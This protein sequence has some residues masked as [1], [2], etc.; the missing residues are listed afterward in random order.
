MSNPSI[1]NSFGT[2]SEMAVG[3]QRVSYFRLPTITDQGLADVSR[4]PRTIKVLLEAVLRNE[5]GVE[6]TREDVEKLIH[7]NPKAPA[8]VE[9]PFKPARV[10]MQD[11]TGVPAIVDLA[12]LRSAMI[13]LGKDPQRINPELPVDLVIDHSVQVDRYGTAEALAANAQLEFSRNRERY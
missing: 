6:V 9:I 4:L 8:Q 11:F 1:H 10:L 3:P 12:A 2:L 5:N 7:Y 13:R